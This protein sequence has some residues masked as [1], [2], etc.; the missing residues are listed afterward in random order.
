ME[1]ATVSQLI[2]RRFGRGPHVPAEL[3]RDAGLLRIVG[4]ASCR[5]FK[6]QTVR[7]EVLETLAAA[8]LSA[9]SK[10]DLQQ[11]DIVLV[12]DPG[13]VARL[14]ALLSRQAWIADTPALVIFLANNHRQRQLHAWRDRPFANDHLDAFFNASVDA[15]I[16]LAFFVAAAEAAGL[17]CCAI[18]AVRN[19]LPEVS[20]MLHLPDHVFPIAGLGVGYPAETDPKIS[21]RLPLDRTVHHD[22]FVE[23]AETDVDAY[24]ARRA[25]ADRAQ[26]TWS[27]AKVRSYARPHRAD[28]GAFVRRIGFKLD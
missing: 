3:D 15:G 22:R 27:E 21:P 28:F 13:L 6:P 4:R 17:G 23:I 7:A 19:H 16:S 24:D 12:T 1:D 14:K 5:H 10:S 8:A 26:T 11:R 9:P 20:E 2:S 18:S 25:Q